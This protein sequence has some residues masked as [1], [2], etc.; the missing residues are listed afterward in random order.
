M[1]GPASLA[2]AGTRFVNERLE[3]AGVKPNRISAVFGAWCPGEDSNL[4]GFHH[5]YLKPARLPIPPPGLGATHKG[6]RIGLS[7]D[8]EAVIS[9][10]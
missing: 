6:R 8:Q 3:A 10:R 2:R 7:T 4:H 5:W 1:D 9:N